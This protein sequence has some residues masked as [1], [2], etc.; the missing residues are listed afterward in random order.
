MV[1]ERATAIGYD[2]R[3]WRCVDLCAWP[4]A[5]GGGG[6]MIAQAIGQRPPQCG[7]VQAAMWRGS[8]RGQVPMGECLVAVGGSDPIHSAKGKG[9]AQPF[10]CDRRCCCPL[11]CQPLRPSLVEVA[12]ITA[13]LIPIRSSHTLR[14]ITALTSLFTLLP[15]SADDHHRQ[16][17]CDAEACTLHPAASQ[18][19]SSDDVNRYPEPLNAV[20]HSRPPPQLRGEFPSHLLLLPRQ[21]EPQ[22]PR[23][24]PPIHRRECH[25][26]HPRQGVP[27]LSVSVERFLRFHPLLFLLSLPFV[28][29]LRVLH[30]GGGV[31]PSP[32]VPALP[33]CPLFRSP[34][35]GC[36]G[37]AQ[38]QGRS[39]VPEADIVP[40]QGKAHLPTSPSSTSPSR[41]EAHSIHLSTPSQPICS[42]CSFSAT[43]T[44]GWPPV[45]QLTS[46][47]LSATVA[48]VGAGRGEGE[49]EGADGGG[50]EVA[51]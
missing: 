45:V 4:D 10:D 38:G 50:G 43:A 17:R 49:G 28:L 18:A 21:R 46:A 39:E 5:D 23:P 2:L 42:R 1:D 30:P 14:S 47:S 19:R 40:H 7:A 11:H 20:P 34:H 41:E 22:Q 25:A 48:A 27:R 15:S 31:P 33:E 29:R 24:S 6:P 32:A 9:A 16:R 51:S 35:V 44:R 13:F 8:W 36:S 26:P 12:F 3:H 37:A